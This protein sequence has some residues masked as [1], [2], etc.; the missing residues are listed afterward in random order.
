MDESQREMLSE[1]SKLQRNAYCVISQFSKVLL[2]KLNGGHLGFCFIIWG[3][4]GDGGDIVCKYVHIL[5]TEGKD[6][7]YLQ[8]L[9]FL[10]I[11]FKLCHL[12]S[13]YDYRYCLNKG[14]HISF[15]SKEHYA[16]ATLLES[17]SDKH[18]HLY[19]I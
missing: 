11:L 12:K 1:K 10:L 19:V 7:N 15:F 9:I 16:K 2:L 6:I 4:E 17:F 5:R 8:K 14:L 18:A 13:K 3:K